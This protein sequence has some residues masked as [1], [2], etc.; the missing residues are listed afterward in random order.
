M[1][2]TCHWH[3]FGANFSNVL[4]WNPASFH[5]ES[6]CWYFDKD[7]GWIVALLPY[8]VLWISEKNN[9]HNSHK[10]IQ[11]LY[12]HYVPALQTSKKWLGKLCQSDFKLNDQ[13]GF[14]HPSVVNED[15]LLTIVKNKPKILM[16]VIATSLKIDISPAFHHL[17][18]F[19]LKKK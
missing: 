17:K 12:L 18:R 5:C 3:C 14:R 16:G 11:K 8:C 2:A 1:T 9:C 13:P 10:I 19:R 4:N 6:E 7:G 15:V